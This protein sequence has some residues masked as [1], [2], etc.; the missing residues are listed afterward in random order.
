MTSLLPG[1][2]R[3]ERT[4][5]PRS[6]HVTV[7][8]WFWGGHNWEEDSTQGHRGDVIPGR[9]LGGL[10]V[11]IVGIYS[12][13]AS[14]EAQISDGS[15]SITAQAPVYAG[16]PY[17]PCL[18]CGVAL[19]QSGGSRVLGLWSAVRDKR[20]WHPRL[21]LSRARETTAGT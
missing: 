17:G 16:S 2:A 12:S 20:H 18:S 8:H 15:C 10:T 3:A 21:C 11:A 9:S 6:F 19:P 13:S 4:P 1:S 7:R 14:E 5:W